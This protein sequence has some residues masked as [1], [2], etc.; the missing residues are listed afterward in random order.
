[1]DLTE[2]SIVIPTLNEA[3]TLPLLLDDL[4]RQEK[5]ALQVIIADGGSSDNTCRIVDSFF[6]DRRL[7]G[8]LLKCAAGRGRQLNCGAQAAH[9]EWLLFLHADSRLKDKSQLLDALMY[10]KNFASSHGSNKVAGRFAL[11]FELQKNDYGL[12]YFFYEA[13]AVLGRPGCIHGDQGFLIAKDFFG[14]AGPFREDLPVMEDTCLAE[15]VRSK[16]QWVLLPGEITT[17]ARRFQLEGLK[18][19]QT[20]NALMMNFL[21]IGWLDFFKKAPQVYRS[22]DRTNRLQLQPFFSLVSDLLKPL[23]LKQRCDLWLATGRYVRGQAW[24]IGW[25]FDCKNAFK[26]GKPHPSTPGPWLQWFD[27]WFEPMTNHWLGNLLTA[28]LVRTWFAKRLWLG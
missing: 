8:Q 5:V 16:G 19:R 18:A 10:L 23:P 1:M 2:L 3:E 15:A 14:E 7:P 13:K 6:A 4:A 22:Q 21:V 12:G 27:K 25:F 11:R 28:V 26:S 24:Q 9:S 20:L 17:S